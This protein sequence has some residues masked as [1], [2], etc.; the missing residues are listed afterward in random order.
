VVLLVKNS[1]N[2]SKPP[3]SDGLK[4]PRTRSLGKPSGKKSGGQPGHEGQTLKMSVKPDEVQIH[5]V[6]CCQHCHC[7]L[8]KTVSVEHERRQVF[9]LPPVR[10]MVTEH[11][12]K[13]KVC[14]Q[15]GQKTKAEFPAGVSQ[16]VQYGPRIKAQMLYFNQNYGIYV[17]QLTSTKSRMVPFEY[18][19]CRS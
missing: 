17:Y 2:S 3:S 13:V 6:D 1:Q 18:P 14:P 10:V 11:Q 15:C 12:A 19:T 5:R 16:T 4:K 8:E 9:D 7:N